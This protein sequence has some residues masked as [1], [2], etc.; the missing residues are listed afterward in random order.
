MRRHAPKTWQFSTAPATLLAAYLLVLQGFA[1]GVAFGFV[2]GTSGLFAGSICFSK[3]SGPNGSDP[4]SPAGSPH[5]GDV[6]CI[7]HCSGMGDATVSGFQFTNPPPQA[8][9]EIL[10]P[11]SPQ[12]SH[13]RPSTFPLGSR[14]PPVS[15]A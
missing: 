13:S 11:F 1:V 8:L 14:A 4:A 6:C 5:R 9:A 7:L 15:A 3:G 10:R 12:E 2:P